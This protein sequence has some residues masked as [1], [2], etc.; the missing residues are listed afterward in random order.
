MV[1]SSPSKSSGSAPIPFV[2]PQKKGTQ[3]ITS[4][5]MKQLGFGRDDGTQQPVQQQL[6]EV[7]VNAAR[8]AN[9]EQKGQAAREVHERKHA[10]ILRITI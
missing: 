8:K 6:T 9:K 1:N 3:E 4:E 5:T 7:E 2:S 10:A